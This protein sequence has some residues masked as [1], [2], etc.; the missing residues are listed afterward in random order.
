MGIVDVLFV[1]GLIVGYLVL[2][3]FAFAELTRKGDSDG[4]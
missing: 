2:A 4:K 1:L 3:A